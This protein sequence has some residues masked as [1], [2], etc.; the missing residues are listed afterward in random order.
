MG[1]VCL[2]RRARSAGQG[3]PHPRPRP[4]HYLVPGEPE[5]LP[6]RADEGGRRPDASERPRRLDGP[7]TE[8]RGGLPRRALAE[9]EIDRKSTRLNSSHVAI[10]YAVFCL[11]KKK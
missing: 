9:R 2:G 5:A 7:R 6:L 8:S 3:L 1:C 4:V 10:S 11:K